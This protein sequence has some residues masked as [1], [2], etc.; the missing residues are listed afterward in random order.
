[1]SASLSL[2]RLRCLRCSHSWVPRSGKIRICPRCKSH[3][4]DRPK[5]IPGTV[6]ERSAK[7]ESLGQRLIRL[8]RTK[9]LR[10]AAAHGAR[11][12]LLFGSV[13]RGTDSAD[14]DF[15]F[16]VDMPRDH[17]LLDRAELMVELRELLG[18]PVDVVTE[19]NLYAPIRSRVLM[20]A[21]SL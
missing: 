7:S 8:N 11:N 9:I 13:A 21:V 1:M 2:P 10:L 20:D 17:S 18:R 15:D 4:W 14:S 12:V 19:R 5:G 16:L 3:L 6:T